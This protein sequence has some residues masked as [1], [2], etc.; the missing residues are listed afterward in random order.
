MRPADFFKIT[1]NSTLYYLV[2][3]LFVF[4]LH[5][6]ATVLASMLF[7]FHLQIDYSRI[8]FLVSRYDWFFDS[9]KIIF[10]AGP[11]IN[12]ILAVFMIV[13]AYRYKEFTGSLKLFFIWGFVH[14]IS[15][16]LGSAYAGALLSEGFGHVLI[17]M[18][19]PDTGKLII[20]L[21]AMFSL[22][23]LGLAI[24]RM[25][26]LSANTYFNLLKPEQRL[27]FIIAQVIIP[28]LAGTIFIVAIR[29]PMNYYE[30]ARV[31][32]PLIIV[33]S[34]SLN[35]FGV[36]VLYFDEDVRSIK[37]NG[38]LL[39]AAIV[40]YSIYRIGLHYPITI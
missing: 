13:V 18:F 38:N 29:L 25:F 1:I 17:W 20:T 32:T 7:G 24:T 4:L 26:L 36:P 28:F 27:A 21:L 8:I 6:A 34:V 14:S 35:S 16:F 33:L 10:S 15:V 11:L 30:L 22:V 40:L 9:V 31:L 37:I 23:A 3:Y 2:S 5:Q 12:L 19:M 39:V